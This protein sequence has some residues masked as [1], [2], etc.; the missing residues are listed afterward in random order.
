MKDGLLTSDTERYL[1][2]ALEACR[3]A[4]E[5]HRAHFRSAHLQ[6]ERKKDSSPVT[7]ADRASEEAIRE[8][9]HR[10]TPGLKQ[11]LVLF[12]S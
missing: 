12:S 2:A 4:G 5:I 6:V 3:R 1:L 8:I 11:V 10:A 9:L 7:V